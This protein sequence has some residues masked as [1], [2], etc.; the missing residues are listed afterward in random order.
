M[1]CLKSFGGGRCGAVSAQVAVALVAITGGA[2]VAVEG[3]M[4]QAEK[5]RAQA[6]ADTAALAAAADLYKRWNTNGGLDVDA[7]GISPPTDPT[8]GL[9]Y[10]SA[11]AIAA[12]NGYTTTTA[13]ISP[14]TTTGSGSTLQTV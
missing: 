10:K 4:L 5:R 13:T 3:G 9:A 6:R 8:T 1:A 7:S 12:A 11:V 2:A 14:N